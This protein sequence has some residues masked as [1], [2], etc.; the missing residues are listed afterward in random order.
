MITLKRATAQATRYACLNFHYAKSV[1]SATDSYNV[2]NENGE[3]CGVIIFG[4]GA[5]PHIASP[6]GMVHGEVME[7]V[8]VALNGKQPCTSECV[9]AAL[10]QLHKDEPQVK[11]VVSFADM[12]QNHF[13]TIYQATNWIYLGEMNVGERG[14][15]IV[16]GK[17]LHPKT[18]HDHK[19]VQSVS[20]LREHIDP[21]AQEIK[22]KGKRKYIWVFDKKLRKEWQKKSVPYPKKGVG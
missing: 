6:F 14:G 9:G 19:W 21:N 16:N 17:K 5:T 13:G 10:R 7:L 11:L 8:R 4:V 20:W 1:P 18:I 15:F 22:T 2:Y 3:W 12:D